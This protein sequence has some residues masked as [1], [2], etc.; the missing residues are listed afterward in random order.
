MRGDA[1]FGGFLTGRESPRS[2]V[3][4]WTSCFS[5]QGS[6]AWQQGGK[7]SSTTMSSRRGGSR[8]VSWGK[9]LSHRCCLHMARPLAPRRAPT[10]MV[11]WS[12]WLPESTG[13]SQNR[14]LCLRQGCVGVFTNFPPLP[15]S[16]ML[17][18]CA[19]CRLLVRARS[20]HPSLPAHPD[21]SRQSPCS[22]ARAFKSE[23]VGG[24][25]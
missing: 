22:K 12:A 25:D 1:P 13:T 14:F 8:A 24:D 19:S 21:K 7:A 20:W 5:Y 16:R 15:A 17:W 6:T 18:T 3:H 11:P 23:P 2:K 10:D 4:P 9:W